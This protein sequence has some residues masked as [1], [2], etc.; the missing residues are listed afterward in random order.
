MCCD[1]CPLSL[2]FRQQISLMSA[3]RRVKGSANQEEE[4]DVTMIDMGQQ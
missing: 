1:Y 3:M 2:L 4:K